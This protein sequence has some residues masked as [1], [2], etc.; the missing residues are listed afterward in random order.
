MQLNSL[1][2]FLKYQQRVSIF[3]SDWLTPILC[4]YITDLPITEVIAKIDRA[5]HSNVQSVVTIATT[6]KSTIIKAAEKA[7]QENKLPNSLSSG[8]VQVNTEKRNG[9][10]EDIYLV[11]VIEM[12]ASYR[13]S[14]KYTVGNGE[15]LRVDLGCCGSFLPNSASF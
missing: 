1:F 12:I 9:K 14:R 15:A 4:L 10:Y 2:D 13:N 11:P 5:V 8:S 6:R 7:S 3:I